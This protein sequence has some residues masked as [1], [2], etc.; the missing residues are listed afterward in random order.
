MKWVV[1]CVCGCV[2]V[3]GQVGGGSF[4]AKLTACHCVLR[5]FGGNL[6]ILCDDNGIAVGGGSFTA[7]CEILAEILPFSTMELQ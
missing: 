3:W 1:V 7:V 4:A 5:N 6:A 2:I